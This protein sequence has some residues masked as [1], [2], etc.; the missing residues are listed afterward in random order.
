MLQPG[1]A[2]S[3][4]DPKARVRF[5]QA[6]PPA[7]LGLILIAAQELNEESGERFGRAPETLA[8]EQRTKNRLLGNTRV[9][10]PRQPFAACLTT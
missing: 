2:L 5:A 1:A 4:V 9:E 8:R 10:F 3:R 6:Q 7:V